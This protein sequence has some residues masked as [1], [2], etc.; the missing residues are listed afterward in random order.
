MDMWFFEQ[1]FGKPIV[2]YTGHYI[3]AGILTGIS[4][5]QSVKAEIFL[6]PCFHIEVVGFDTRDLPEYYEKWEGDGAIPVSAVEM[7][8][9]PKWLY[10]LME[11]E[12]VKYEHAPKIG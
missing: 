3:F 2:V 1:H 5:N 4:D 8:R 10:N 6:N 11:K 7:Y 9:F 12:G